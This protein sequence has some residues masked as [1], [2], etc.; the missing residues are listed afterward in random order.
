MS[1]TEWVNTHDMIDTNTPFEGV[2]LSRIDKD[3]GPEQ[4][5]HYLEIEG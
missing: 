4:L 1:G 2:K 3:F 5:D